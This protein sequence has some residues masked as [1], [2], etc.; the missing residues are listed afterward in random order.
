VGITPGGADGIGRAAG[1]GAGGGIAVK[2][3][4]FL[5]QWYKDDKR[6]Q[7]HVRKQY[8]ALVVVFLGMM[9]FNVTEIHRAGRAAAKAASLE[10][11][12]VGAEAVVHEFGVLTKQLNEVKTRAKLVEQMDPRVDMA[13]LLAEMSHT[14][15]DSVVLRKLEILAEPFRRAEETGQTKGSAVRLA[16]RAGGSEKDLPL[17]RV[18]FRIV[19]TGVAAHPADVPDLVCKLEASPYFQRVQ[20]SFYGSTRAQAGARPA[21]GPP[22]G[23]A[24]VKTPGVSGVTEFE[25]VCYL[26]NYKDLDE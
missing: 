14:I 25:I 22:E 7:W 21:P 5:P 11:Q 6:R 12:R 16:G 15:D 24:A 1:T 10:N 2:E 26:A 9:I 13:A 23:A 20:P 4:D 3:L 17:G 19:L 18:R 8:V